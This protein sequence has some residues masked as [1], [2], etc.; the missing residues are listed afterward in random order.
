MCGLA[1]SREFL[2]GSGIFGVISGTG[3]DEDCRFSAIAVGMG[4]FGFD[5]TTAADSAGPLCV[6]PGWD[7]CGTDR[8]DSGRP[9][10]LASKRITGWLLPFLKL[11]RH[12]A[13]S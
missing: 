9:R 5:V 11:P 8:A 10:S 1:C 3:W 2:R 6:R 13:L 7:G 4:D 12:S